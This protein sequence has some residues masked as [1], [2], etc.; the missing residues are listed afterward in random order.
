MKVWRVLV[1]LLLALAT[2]SY[3]TVAATIGIPAI[4]GVKQYEKINNSIPVYCIGKDITKYFTRVVELE[5]L[6]N[7]HEKHILVVDGKYAKKDPKLKAFLKTKILSGVPV[8]VINGNTDVVKNLFK[9]QFC[10]EVVAGRTPDGKPIGKETVYGYIVYPIDNKTLMTKVFISTDPSFEAILEAYKWASNNMPN[11]PVTIKATPYWN[12]IYQ[13]DYTTGDSW[14]PYGRLNIRT[15]YYKLYNDGSDTYDWY[16]IHVRQ[17]SVPGE[18]LWSSGWKTADMYTWIDADYY[19]SNYFL[20]DYSPTTTPG[21]TTV[22]VSIG[23]SAGE[24]GAQVSASQSWSYTIQDVF[25]HDQS[26]YSKE[27]AKWWHDV[28]EGKAVGSDT[29]QIEPGA[30]IRV[31]NGATMD[32]KEHYGV[33]YG[34]WNILWWS[35]TP[36]GWIEFRI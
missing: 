19:Q 16:D 21:T 12:Q 6:R 27:L 17:Q 20:S 5:E 34:K 10:P 28:D 8:I 30:T 31:P 1:G 9:G 23:V 35:Y 33:R 32:W 13:L 25:V 4:D 36:E 11:V 24:N 26:D 29:Y 14:K 15:L 3:V 2:L 18:E 7:I 22:S